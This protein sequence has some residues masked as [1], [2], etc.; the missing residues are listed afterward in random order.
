MPQLVSLLGQCNLQ[1]YFFVCHSAGKAGGSGWQELSSQARCSPVRKLLQGPL[2]NI[3]GNRLRVSHPSRKHHSVPARCRLESSE[4][5]SGSSGAVEENETFVS[6]PAGSPLVTSASP[7]NND[8]DN[9]GNDDAAVAA[10]REGRMGRAEALKLVDERLGQGQDRQALALMS[11]LQGR[12]GGL[13][14]FGAASQRFLAPADST[15]GAVRQALQLAALAGVGTAWWAL[16]LSQMQLLGVV[17]IANGGGGEAL[18]VD[19]LGNALST[20]Y[21]ERVAQHEAGHF[22][23]S[24]LLGILPR[25]Y[26]LSGLDAFQR[27]GA[28]N[29]QAGTTFVKSGKLSS[30]MLGRYSCVALAGVATEYLKYDVAEGGVADI[31][32]LDALFKGLGFTQKKAD[33]QVRWAVLNTVTLLRRHAKTHDMLVDAMIAGKSVGDCIAIIEDQLAG[34]QDI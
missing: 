11:A 26:T 27:Y 8:N 17:L 23:V 4:K 1:N 33:S 9:S 6:G 7:P 31:Q 28:L 25:G 12:P 22:L 30:G 2:Q 14:G 5:S 20:S 21:R 24:Y 19:T 10:V 16:H 18:V 15:L 29:V 32:Q 3:Y 34:V 13:R